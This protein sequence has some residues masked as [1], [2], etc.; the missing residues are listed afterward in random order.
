[1]P[2]SSAG[3]TTPDS[4]LS[5]NCRLERLQEQHCSLE[6]GSRCASSRGGGG[7]KPTSLLLPDLCSYPLVVS[8]ALSSSSS[9]SASMFA[10]RST[11]SP[12]PG[13]TSMTPPPAP[14][15]RGT[16]S[17]PLGGD[18]SLEGAVSVPC[19]LAGQARPASPMATA[20]SFSS[21]AVRPVG[22]PLRPPC[23]ARLLPL[24]LAA[25]APSTAPPSA[26]VSSLI[27]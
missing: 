16:S 18:S 13:P 6:H 15:C 2:H 27:D 7:K 14:R 5:R 24:R 17:L 23:S 10:R 26:A 12:S 1:M 19:S 4:I 22:A 20:I 11:H 8:F 21:G 9:G 25:A 3:F